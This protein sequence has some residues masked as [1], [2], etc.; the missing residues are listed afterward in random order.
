MKDFFSVFSIFN[1]RT[2]FLGGFLNWSFMA[3]I[4]SKLMTRVTDL[5]FTD[6]QTLVQKTNYLVSVFPDS[7][8]ENRFKL[9]SDPFDQKAYAERIKP[10]LD[11][12][13]ESYQSKFDN[14]WVKVFSFLGV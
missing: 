9:S 12:F 3:D 6:I 14:S 11:D 4:I 13:E 1:S 5:P 2:I 7:S 10:Y 8:Q